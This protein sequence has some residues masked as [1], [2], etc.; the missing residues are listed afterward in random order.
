MLWFGS[1]VG[2]FMAAERGSVAIIFALLVTTLF[3]VLALS[4][5][6]ARAYGAQARITTALDAASLAGAKAL[7]GGR[8][9][10]EIRA[11]AQAFFDQSMTNNMSG[12]DLS[13]SNFQVQIERSKANVTVSVDANIATRFGRVLGKERI[14]LD[15]S[16]TVQYKTRNVELAMALDVTRSME[17][18]D[19]IGDLKSAAKDVLKTMFDEAA[20]EDAVRVSI[21]P[22]ASAVNFG[23]YA[24]AVT[25][26]TSIDQ[27]AVERLGGNPYS[28]FAPVGSDALQAV[29]TSPSGYNCPTSAVIPL[30]G[31][32]KEPTLKDAIDD[33]APAGATA[34][35]IGVAAGWYTLSPAWTSIWPTGSK[36]RAYAPDDTIKSVLL[37]TDGLFNRSWATSQTY[38]PAM[39]DESYARFQSLCT[40]MKEQKVVVFT[41]GFGL[42]DPRAAFEL[43]TCA[44]GG[45]Q[46]FQASNGNDLKK[47]FKEVATQLKSMRIT[48]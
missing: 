41:V 18:D 14:S 36:P 30:S 12:G 8:S 22:W 31:R 48:R 17:D 25:A 47:A 39:T 46:F 1:S 16:S 42:T 35:H 45:G 11:S 15:R 13:L 3:G 5:D 24:A 4:I 23:T 37:M 44:A 7:D 33:L 43:E 28:D 6:M 34:G 9:D 2:R 19:K 38:D 40:K 10:A 27:C 21:V 26:S 20:S 32:S 29:T